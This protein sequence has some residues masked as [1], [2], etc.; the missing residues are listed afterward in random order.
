[1]VTMPTDVRGLLDLAVDDYLLQPLY[2]QQSWPRRSYRV[3]V[4]AGGG[5]RNASE[6]SS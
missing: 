6:R 3:V 5:C 1:M 4:T 2:S